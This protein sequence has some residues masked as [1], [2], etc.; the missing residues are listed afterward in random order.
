MTGRPA[1]RAA[2]A[3]QT[4]G[5][6][7][8]PNG[9]GA[10]PTVR[11]LAVVAVGAAVLE[12]A[13]CATGTPRSSRGSAGVGPASADVGLE[14][15]SPSLGPEDAVARFLEAAG[16]EN[17]VAMAGLFGTAAG[18]LGDSGG[19]GCA[20]RRLR[21]WTRAGDACPSRTDVLRRMALIAAL[22]DRAVLRAARRAFP[23]ASGGTVRLLVDLDMAGRL[24]RAVP[25]VVV[26]TDAGSW[27]VQEVALDKLGRR[28]GLRPVGALTSRPAPPAPRRR[29]AGAR[30]PRGDRPIQS[31]AR[32]T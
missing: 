10:L 9:R 31:R 15:P 3:P 19:A 13:A 23:H 16:R 1:V 25:F 32:E 12:T 28:P 30:R 5:R 4:D 7:K 18:A 11:V 8:R 17:H 22:L 27:L 14:V 2:R 6:A 24:V 26:R 20:L 29:I 21:S